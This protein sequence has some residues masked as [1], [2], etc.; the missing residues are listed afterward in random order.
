MYN[1]TTNEIPQ[2]IKLPF[3]KIDILSDQEQYVLKEYGRRLEE[4]E[5]RAYELRALF[6]VGNCTVGDVFLS[7]DDIS[8]CIR[9]T[10]SLFATITMLAGDIKG[11]AAWCEQRK[12][13]YGDH[14][15]HI[16]KELERNNP[17]IEKRTQKEIEGIVIKK[18]ATNQVLED[19]WKVLSNR[20]DSCK[21]TVEKYIYSLNIISRAYHLEM[22][23]SR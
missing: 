8:M 13:S 6:N 11:K 3:E 20:A 7:L 15:F 1:F 21:A 2:V 18:N 19:A 5:Q 23:E 14:Y 4:C 10:T 16:V 12:R 17:H 9:I 22:Q